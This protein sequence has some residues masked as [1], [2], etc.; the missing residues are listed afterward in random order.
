MV[1]SSAQA[2]MYDILSD[3]AKWINSAEPVV[4]ATVVHTWGSSPREVGAQMAFTPGGKV[5][6]SV[7]GGCVEG[8]VIQNGLQTLSTH[9][10]E[11]LRFGVADETAFEVGLACGGNIEILVRPL[12]PDFFHTIKAEMDAQRS[13]AVLSVVD[14]PPE[15][16]GRELLV[17]E[18]G[19]AVGS[20]SKDLDP[21]ARSAAEQA[22]REGQPKSMDLETGTGEQVHVFINTILPA[23]T[24]IMV[25]GVHIAVSLAAIAKAVGFQTIVIDPRRTFSSQER[26]PHVDRLIQS[27]PQEAFEQIKL[28]R[29][30][31]VAML[32][33]DPKI[34]DPALKIVLDSPVFYI[35][36]LG[37]RK[38]H[39][40]RRQRLLADGLTEDQLK[41]IQGPIGLDI[42]AKTPEE[43]AL[44]I[45][46][47]IVAVR[48][49][50][51][52]GSAVQS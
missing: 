50:Q 16:I 35:G 43:I 7:S 11:L 33:H 2:H 52:A 3:T 5:T 45:M 41:R 24:L 37:S 36:A 38:T 19:E 26:F 6:G 25:G 30:T 10:P 39:Q 1:S 40:S 32:T 34:D 20:L 42:G 8:A 22:L 17:S 9:Q 13:F 51:S 48:R 29:S 47:E 4:M 27:W 15:L 12:D 21:A 46:A 23:P 49:G 44:S 28:T 31:C 14:G 18:T